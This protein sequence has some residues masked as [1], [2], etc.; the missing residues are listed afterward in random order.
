MNSYRVRL[1]A[2]PGVRLPEKTD[3]KLNMGEERGSMVSVWIKEILEGKE[4]ARIPVGL[5]FD[6]TLE[7]TSSQ[8]AVD[9]AKMTAGGIASFVT[10]VTGVG[11]STLE[12]K[13]CFEIT[14]G[15]TEREYLQFY[16][17]LPA[18]KLS[19]GVIDPQKL[20]SGIDMYLAIGDQKYRARV[21]RASVWFRKGVLSVDSVDRFS[22]FWV[23]LEALNKILQETMC[24]EDAS[25]T[26]SGAKAFIT[27]YYDTTGKMFR[28]LR[29]YRVKILHST[30]NLQDIAT[31]VSNLAPALGSVLFGAI[32]FICGVQ[33]P[34]SY[35]K[36]MLSNAEPLR[37]VFSGIITAE[38][39]EDACPEGSDYP[40]IQ[41]I[42]NLD[43]VS[44]PEDK[45]TTTT[46]T[47]YKFLIGKAVIKPIGYKVYGEGGVPFNAGTGS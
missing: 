24:V 4:G 37:M 47:T 17:E 6:V 33:P 29:D 28:N 34:W 36:E 23:G 40:E 5:T 1:E 11:L 43:A 39:P 30:T 31:D 27:K 44:R 12:A 45:I 19:R 38:K 18:G 35:P 15:K 14:Q 21:A 9:H 2:R 26:M 25:E 8:E 46:T 20:I 13:K 32:Q 42:H 22:S 3:V 10:L 7:A 16:S 41:V